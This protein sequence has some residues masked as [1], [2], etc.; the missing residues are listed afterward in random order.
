MGSHGYLS[1]IKVNG[2]VLV[3]NMFKEKYD[4]DDPV[5]DIVSGLKLMIS[6]IIPV[7]VLANLNF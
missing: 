5:P 6:S 2:K 4:W 7:S 1:A 3:Q